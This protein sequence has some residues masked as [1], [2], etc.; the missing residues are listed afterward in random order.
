[1]PVNSTGIF[2]FSCNR[3]VETMCNFC[4]H[5]HLFRKIYNNVY[6]KDPSDAD[7]FSE[8]RKLAPLITPHKTANQLQFEFL[9][10]QEN[11]RINLL[12]GPHG[13]AISKIME[14]RKK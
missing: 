1:M 7:I 11:D 5:D 8:Y 3:L 9:S 10:I 14:A 4:T 13:R 2:C 12:A 6:D